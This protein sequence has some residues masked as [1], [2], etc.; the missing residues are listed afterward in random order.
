MD[1]SKYLG[2]LPLEELTTLYSSPWTCQAVLRTL[3]PL[4][5]Q[6]VLRQVHLDGGIPDAW[7]RRI[8]TPEHSRRADMALDKL[9][10]LRVLAKS[11]GGVWSLQRTFQYA[12]RASQ[13]ASALCCGALNALCIWVFAS[14]SDITDLKRNTFSRAKGQATLCA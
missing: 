6:I 2:T 13:P 14:H 7:M 8:V 11:A 9:Q 1:F 3:E 10:Q 12:S 4:A 5:Q